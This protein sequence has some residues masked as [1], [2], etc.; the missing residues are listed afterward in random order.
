MTALNV[1]ALVL[2]VIGLTFAARGYRDAATA[3]QLI[4]AM[5]GG[6]LSALA[7]SLALGAMLLRVF[8]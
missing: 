7:L 1:I 8:A 3:E 4:A 5:V 6:L 2:A